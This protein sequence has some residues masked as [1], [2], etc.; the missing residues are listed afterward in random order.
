MGPRSP[1]ERVLQG[2]RDRAVVFGGRQQEGVGGG[3]PLPQLIHGSRRRPLDVVVLV[4]GG[5][6]GQP[7]V[8]LDLRAAPERAP[9]PRAGARS[10]RSRGGGCPRSPGSSSRPP[11]SVRPAST[12]STSRTF[13]PTTEAPLASLLFQLIPYSVRSSSPTAARLIRSPPSGP[14]PIPST[15]TSSSSGRVTPRRVSSPGDRVAALARRSRARSRRSGPRVLLGG[16]EVL[17]AEVA[18]ELGVVDVDARD[19]DRAL[20]RAQAPLG[21][22]DPPLVAPEA[23]RGR[24]RCRDA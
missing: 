7:F 6:S 24:S 14:I 17:A 16:E 9:A 2:A 21:G 3:D 19:L 4:V 13:S 23:R 20:D 5:E 10:S 11:H 12:D 18:G 1:V 22:G 8:E 15:V